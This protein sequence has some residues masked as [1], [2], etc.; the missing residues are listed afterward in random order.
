M[1][2]QLYE[3]TSCTNMK[4]QLMNEILQKKLPYLDNAQMAQLQNTLLH[5]LW[6][7][8]ISPASDCEKNENNI[9]NADLLEM[10]VSAKK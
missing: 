8:E 4:E 10:F 3:N 2:V 9:S 1:L 6:N 7:V 5:C